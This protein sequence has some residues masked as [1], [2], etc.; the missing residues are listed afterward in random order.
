[1]YDIIVIIIILLFYYYN[2]QAHIRN[3]KYFSVEK[4]MVDSFKCIH[5]I[6]L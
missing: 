1:M 4:N 5:V 2:M 3:D 6:L